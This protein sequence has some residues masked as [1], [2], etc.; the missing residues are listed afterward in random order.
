MILL[1]G[2]FVLEHFHYNNYVKYYYLHIINSCMEIIYPK[3]PYLATYHF[4]EH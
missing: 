4:N 1:G 3:M 2:L